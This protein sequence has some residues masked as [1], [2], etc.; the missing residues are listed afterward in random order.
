MSVSVLAVPTEDL[1]RIIDAIHRSC[2]AHISATDTAGI[3]VVVREFATRTRIK[4]T[5]STNIIGIVARGTDLVPLQMLKSR[6]LG[7]QGG[8]EGKAAGLLTIHVR[9]HHWLRHRLQMASLLLPLLQVCTLSL[10]GFFI[11]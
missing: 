9:N 6:I 7:E 1:V 4:T 10:V 5:P 8:W 2:T 11:Q 3:I